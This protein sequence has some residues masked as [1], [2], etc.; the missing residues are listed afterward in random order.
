MRLGAPIF[1][2]YQ[3][4]EAW[5]QAVRD[6]GYAAA[7]CPVKAGAPP[8]EIKAYG[9]AAAKH[10]IVIA[11]V[12]VWNNPL[13]LDPGEK[14]KALA[15][16]CAQLRLADEIGARCCVNIAGSKNKERWDGP[17][18]DNFAQETF[19][20]IVASVRH[21]IDTVRPKR[22]YYTL[23]P[24][25]WAIPDTADSYLELIRAVDRDR[26]A[27]HLD[28]VNVIRTPREH[29]QNAALIGEWFGTLGPHIRSCHAKDTV[30]E[31][32]FT[33]HTGEAVPGKGRLD[34]GA[35]LRHIEA[36]DPDMPLMIEHL[37]TEAEYDAAARYIRDAAAREGIGL[38]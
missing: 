32:R 31:A 2:E 16:C 11:E 30:L 18:P 14:K 25:A 13:A 7:Y 17:H 29:Y 1:T 34:Y 3:T 28:I 26:F 15:H 23:E 21:I 5:A 33:S 8:S 27:V 22:T 9:E 37:T 19:E 4:P 35:L 36:L 24:M 6:K 12:G 20:E 10:D 38:K